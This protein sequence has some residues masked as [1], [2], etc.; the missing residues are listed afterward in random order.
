MCVEEQL[1]LEHQMLRLI[2]EIL[3]AD[4]FDRLLESLF[5]D[6]VPNAGAGKAHLIGESLSDFTPARLESGVVADLEQ[7]ADSRFN[8]APRISDRF[9][10][11][12]P[13]N[14]R[15]FPPAR[16]RTIRPFGRV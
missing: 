1:R 10:A 11:L 9:A 15:R 2:A 13:R 3:P 6:Q 7:F 14:R 12:S 8:L 16:E 4:L 5:L